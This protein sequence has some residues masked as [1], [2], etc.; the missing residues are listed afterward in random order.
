MEECL[1][2]DL[3]WTGRVHR[4]LFRRSWLR[5]AACE[6]AG[7]WPAVSP[8]DAPAADADDDGNAR[9]PGPS[10]GSEEAGFAYDC[11]TD[12][13]RIAGGQFLRYFQEAPNPQYADTVRLVAAFVELVS[14]QVRAVTAARAQCDGGA[15]AA[16]GMLA[17]LR[18]AVTVVKDVSQAARRQQA[19]AEGLAHPEVVLPFAQVRVLLPPLLT[20]FRVN[21][22]LP[23]AGCSVRCNCCYP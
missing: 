23:C 18:V 14:G 2:A 5:V 21:T 10:W 8:S 1:A 20:L 19:L 12:E 22:G 4:E 6:G 9:A 7:P 11:L 17:A 15:A 16:S 3:L 13:V